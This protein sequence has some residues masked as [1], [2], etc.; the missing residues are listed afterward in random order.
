M[1]GM[2]EY[3]TIKRAWERKISADAAQDKTSK[4]EYKGGGSSGRPSKRFWSMSK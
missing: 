1:R 2:W 3:F 4:K